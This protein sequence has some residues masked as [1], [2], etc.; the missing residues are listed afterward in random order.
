MI[1]KIQ[2]SSNKCRTTWNIIEKLTNNQHF[3]ID[4]Q[5][6]TIDSKFLKYQQEIADAFNKYLSSIINKISK[7][8][9]TNRT[10]DEKVP[11]FN[12][13]LE[14]N[15]VHPRP[16]LVIKA[17]STKEITSIIRALKTKNSPVGM[18]YIF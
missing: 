7:N 11:T 13:Y 6:L 5:E 4:I 14:Q 16:S 18:L 15:H 2:N 10:N 1:K 9:I 3:Q 12:H 17:F 8:N